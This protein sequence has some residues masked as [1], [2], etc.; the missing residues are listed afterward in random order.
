MHAGLLGERIFH[1][2]MSLAGRCRLVAKW[3][4]ENQTH[5]KSQCSLARGEQR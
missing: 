1:C 5:P 2:K 3:N 4:K